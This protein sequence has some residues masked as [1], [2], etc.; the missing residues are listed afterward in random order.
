MAATR[1]TW[2]TGRGFERYYGFLGGET[3][4]WYP[5]IVEDNHFGE[6]PYTPEQGYHLSK[7]LVDQSIQYICDSRQV[8]PEKPWFIYLAFG[9]NHAPHHSPKEWADK[10]KVYPRRS[11]VLTSNTGSRGRCSCANTFPKN[12]PNRYPVDA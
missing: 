6:P 2:P 7:D 4:Q 5:D 11:L 3:N 1:R 12:C 9:A 8:A 10:Y